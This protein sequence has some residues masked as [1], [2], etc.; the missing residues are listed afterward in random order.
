MSSISFT[1]KSSSSSQQNGQT[2]IAASN[3]HFAYEDINIAFNNTTVLL[4]SKY[5]IY[6]DLLLFLSNSILFNDLIP[7][8]CASGKKGREKNICYVKYLSIIM[9]HLL[10][11]D[12]PN[13]DI[14]PMKIY[15]ITDATFKDSTLSEVPLT[16][17]MRKVARL[18]EKPLKQPSENTNIEATDD[19]SLSGTSEHPASKPKAKTDKKYKKKLLKKLNLIEA[20]HSDLHSIGDVPLESLT[21]PADDNPYDTESEIKVIKKF[22]QLE[23]Y[24]MDAELNMSKDPKPSNNLQDESDLESMPGDE[25]GSVSESENLESDEDD[26]HSQNVELSKSEERDANNLIDELADMNAFTDKP[27]LIDS[28]GQLQNEISNLNSKVQNLESSITKQV[29]DKLEELVPSL[30]ATT[31]KETLLELISKSLKTAIPQITA[32]TV[33]KILRPINKQF[34]AF[35]KFEATHF[36]KLHTGL[37]KDLKKKVGISVRKEVHKGMNTV[38]VKLDYCTTKVDQNM[39]KFKK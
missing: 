20:V 36:V 30:V 1:A 29:T 27:S 16:S 24:D 2:I 15:Q 21:K 19:I 32:E 39:K 14:K 37:R 13:D 9:E 5:P 11:E 23:D 25:I 6:K 35:N 3:V 28:L 4:E 12:Y 22:K 26:T 8:L 18:P 17:H 38:K 33:D 34:N 10:G 7:K 31:L